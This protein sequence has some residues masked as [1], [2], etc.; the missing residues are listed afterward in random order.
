MLCCPQFETNEAGEMT[1]E[2]N[3]NSIYTPTRPQRELIDRLGVEVTPG[4]NGTTVTRAI[5]RAMRAYIKAA[6]E[7]NSALTAGKYITVDGLICKI[8][9]IRDHRVQLTGEKRGWVSFFDIEGCQE[10]PTPS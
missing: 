7:A 1:E 9:Q 3:V 10:A 6:Q 4:M 5:D 2:A 8:A